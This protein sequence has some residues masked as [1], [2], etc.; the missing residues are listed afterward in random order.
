ME[1]AGDCQ[2][3]RERLDPSQ[4]PFDSAR[5]AEFV[6]K[7]YFKGAFQANDNQ[8]FHQRIRRSL[9]TYEEAVGLYIKAHDE[10]LS[11]RARILDG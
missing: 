8:E 3:Q 1:A 2:R 7:C 9:T 5:L 11:K 6:A 10:A 4:N